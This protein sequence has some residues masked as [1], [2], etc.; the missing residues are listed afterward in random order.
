MKRLQS[1][2]A[3]TVL[4]AATGLGLSACVA[5]APEPAYYYAPGY[6]SYQPGYYAP[7]PAYGT[8]FFYYESDRRS[9]RHHHRHRGDRHHR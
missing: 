2:L 8:S 9:N 5:T 4:L 3:K 1:A 7:R 6:Y